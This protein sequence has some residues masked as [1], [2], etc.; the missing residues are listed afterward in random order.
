MAKGK[1]PS[2]QAQYRARVQ[3]C[4]AEVVKLA[5]A[6]QRD[7]QP[8]I[9]RAAMSRY[10]DNQREAQRIARERAALRRRQ[11]ELAARAARL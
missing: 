7:Y 1:G 8:E 2:K 5:N 4:T 3:A 11:A 10:L 9:V 6:L